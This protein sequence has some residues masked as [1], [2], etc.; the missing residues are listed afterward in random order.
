MSKL[1]ASVSSLLNL[2]YA[3][4]ASIEGT[5]LVYMKGRIF[6]TLFARFLSP[7]PVI[8]DI[9]NIQNLNRY[10]YALNNPFKYND[11]TGK[12][13]K[14]IIK[15]FT[16]PKVLVALVIGVATAGLASTFIVPAMLATAGIASGTLAGTVVTGAIIGA[17]TG[18]TTTLYMTDGNVNAALKGAALG[19]ITGAVSGSISSL[20]RNDLVRFGVNKMTDGLMNRAQNRDFFDGFEISAVSFIASKYYKSA[21]GYEASTESG[22]E[23][24]KKGY[25]TPP[26]KGANN[27]G[28]QGGSVDPNGMWNEGGI[29]SR[30]LNKIGGINA[31]AGMHDS[32]QIQLQDTAREILNVPLMPVAGALTYMALYNDISC[33]AC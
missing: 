33:P 22:E 10:S 1:A 31:V 21:V 8:Q 29:V 4:H 11:P 13:F 28:V 26:V 19:A 15:F 18:F 24:V 6:D 25:R 5:R 2:G 16:N 20:V 17:S 14:S 7:D 9:Y 3:G 32:F 27:I 30:A 23:A 12:F